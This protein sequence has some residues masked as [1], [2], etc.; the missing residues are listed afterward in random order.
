[1][2]DWSKEGEEKDPVATD[3]DDDQ[4]KYYPENQRRAHRRRSDRSTKGSGP[5]DYYG[6]ENRYENLLQIHWPHRIRLTE[7]GS[8]NNMVNTAENNVFVSSSLL[9]ATIWCFCLSKG[10]FSLDC[11]V[12][13]AS[14]CEMSLPLSTVCL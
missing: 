9:L 5:N 6:D 3:R 14:S 12:V 8:V 10:K 2:I 1:M 11:I 7:H 13:V 4:S